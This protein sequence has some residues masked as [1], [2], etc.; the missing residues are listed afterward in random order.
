MKTNIIRCSWCNLN[1]EL[2]V[3]YHD[4]E[5]GKAIHDD[6]KLFALLILEL[7]QA[8]LSWETIL[9]KRQNFL[10]AFDNFNVNKICNYDQLKVKELLNNKNIIRH[11]LK[12]L[13]TINNAQVFK[14]IQKEYKT[15]ANYIWHFTSN[16]IIYETNKTSS[17]LSDTITKDLKKRGMKFIGTTIIYSYLQAVGIINSHEK[18]CFL[19]KK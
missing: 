6:H 13:A 17:L 7:F 2:Y 18:E 15:F 4:E 1:N 19:Y 12:V 9:N 8:G 3:K 5:W 11:K 16:K 10:T 14:N